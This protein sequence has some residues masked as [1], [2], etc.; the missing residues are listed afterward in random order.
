[1]K[2]ISKKIIIQTIFALTLFLG[3]QDT[4]AYSLTTSRTLQ[5]NCISACPDEGIILKGYDGKITTNFTKKIYL[6]RENGRDTGLSFEIEK[7]E[8]VTLDEEPTTATWFETGA[9][10]DSP[11]A[12]GQWYKQLSGEKDDYY[13]EVYM[14]VSKPKDTKV[15]QIMSLNPDIMSCNNS[16]KKCTALKAGTAW[17]MVDFPIGNQSSTNNWTGENK[18]LGSYPYGYGLISYKVRKYAWIDTNGNKRYDSGNTLEQ[19]TYDVRNGVVANTGDITIASHAYS[20]YPAIYMVNVTEAANLPQTTTLNT[21]SSITQSGATFNWSYSDPENDSQTNYQIL[22]A[23]DSAFTNIV[24]NITKTGTTNVSSVRS[25]TISQGLSANTAY[26]VKMRTYNDTNGWGA[27]TAN[28]TFTTLS[29]PIPVPTSVSAVCSPDGNQITISW[30]DAIGYDTIYF[31]AEDRTTNPLTNTQALWDNNLTSNSKT[32]NIIKGNLYEWWIHTK[33]TSNSNYSTAVG[34]QLTCTGGLCPSDATLTGGVCVCNEA[35]KEFNS[36]QN[37]C[38]DR[39]SMNA[40]WYNN[41][42]NCNNNATDYPSCSTCPAGLEMNNGI[43]SEPNTNPGA[44]SAR[45]ALFNFSPNIT[46]INGTCPLILSAQNTLGCKLVNNN[47]Q[48]W[49]IATTSNYIIDSSVISKPVGTYK[50][51]CTGTNGVEDF[52]GAKACYSNGDTREN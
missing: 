39:C 13:N 2:Y 41:T 45:V 17:I 15:A 10:Y 50:L 12:D 44:D 52:F 4:Y 1:M 47:S 9:F 26:Y 8:F 21:V 49:V 43:C 22:V 40:T 28:R 51:Y 3:T 5:V 11:P 42:C 34:G 7:G 20:F 35:S 19:M 23:T 6:R 16:T 29:N 38:V 32:I 48:T 25:Y 27:Y 24:K 33:D 14:V 31:R 36:S 46:D 30:N 18:I 37:L